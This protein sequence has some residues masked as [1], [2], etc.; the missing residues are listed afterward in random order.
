MQRIFTRMIK[1]IAILSV[2]SAVIIAGGIFAR[3]NKVL[4]DTGKVTI[5]E[6]NYENSTVTVQLSNDDNAIYISDAKQK[7]WEYVP[8][9]KGVD[10]TV[11]FDI[12]WITTTKDYTLSIKGDASTEP[13]SVVLPKQETK[14]KVS[15]DVSTGLVSYTNDN[16][17]N[18][19][20]KKKNGYRWKDAGSPEALKAV[21][22]G[23][24]TNGATI[25]FRL[26]PQNG[27][28]ADAGLRASKEVSVTIPK[29]T[30]APAITVNDALMAIPVVKGMEYRYTD[31]NGIAT[32]PEAGWTEIE[33]DENMPLS[34]IAGKAIC[35]ANVVG[36]GYNDAE[37]EATEDQYIQF[38]LKATTSKQMSNSTTIMIPAQNKLSNAETE[39]FSLEYKS[40]NSFVIKAEM[41]S[42]T[43]RY[44]YC[45]INK[46]DVDAGITLDKPEELTWKEISSS[47]EIS[48]TN[49][50]HSCDEGSK[51]YIR[52]KAAG[53][54][55]DDDY[56]LASNVYTLSSGIQYPGDVTADG[57]CDLASIAG[58][59]RSENSEGYLTFSFFSP[60]NGAITKLKFG[61]SATDCK[62]IASG[63]FKSV[64]SENADQ[65]NPDTKYIITTT[66]Y[67]TSAIES[68]I[69][70][71]QNEN[72]TTLTGMYCIGNSTEYN[73][74]ENSLVKLTLYN[75]SAAI[76]PG[77]ALKDKLKSGLN[78]TDADR[79]GYTKKINR[80]YMSNR[81]F[82]EEYTDDADQEVFR[83]VIKIGRPGQSTT[84]SSVEYDS[85]NITGDGNY[86][87]YQYTDTQAEGDVE[88][89]VIEFHAEKIE[90]ITGITT[91]DTDTKFVI[92]LSNGE[93]VNDVTMNLLS[94]AKLKSGSTGASFNPDLIDEYKS[95]TTNSNGSPALSQEPN[96]DYY[97][98]Y[99]VNIPDYIGLTV[100]DA[101][102]DD[103]SILYD[104]D[105]SNGRVYLSVRKIK[106]Y[107][108]GVEEIKTGYVTLVFSNGFKITKGYRLTL[109]R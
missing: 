93:K 10:G 64:V 98:E 59:C 40:S 31:K 63:D 56:K 102:F 100:I 74:F 27:N 9:A 39:S 29:K 79:I 14:F 103:I 108:D 46:D 22:D 44:E 91:R 105:S 94:S 87:V 86:T 43:N 42:D 81:S 16:S 73:E 83:T 7:K 82:G 45:I 95:I 62:E 11:T 88:Y 41:A 107:M 65:S 15:Y 60:T 3:S 28:G 48:I 69:S 53:K 47:E 58:T 84:V 104:T 77:S 55:G 8:V 57:N 37:V 96:R 26:A 52:R 12:S 67:S 5:T 66:I 25:V 89:L 75:A 78:L 85:I 51:V 54:L 80:V 23:M 92:T 17:R 97:V 101:R 35:S 109:L 30:A 34:K 61:K 76:D 32:N 38:R 13:V 99:E 68:Y 90:K 70:S 18:I 6:I 20:W 33:K 49:T 36:T 72:G 1:Y 21:F 71:G 19:Q 50:K 4:A 106:N 2:M 24:V